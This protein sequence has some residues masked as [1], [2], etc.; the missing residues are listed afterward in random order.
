MLFS[1]RLFFDSLWRAL[2]Y[3][4][5]P[6]IMALALLPQAMLLVLTLSWGYFY[7]QPTQDWVSE[8]LLASHA[9]HDG[10]DAIPRRW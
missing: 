1:M 10:L 5:M 8:F 9:K 4:F 3:C 2:A 7:W 6:R